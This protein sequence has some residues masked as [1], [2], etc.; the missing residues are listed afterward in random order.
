M[1]TLTDLLTLDRI[2]CHGKES[3]RK[4]VLQ[5][6]ATLLG[7]TAENSLFD[8][9]LARERLGSTAIGQGVALPHTRCANITEETG[10]LLILEQGI[11]Y[12]APDQ[13]R[14]DIFFA[15][16]VPDDD[17]A[18]HLET[19]AGLAKAFG[20]EGFADALR[21]CADPASLLALLQTPPIQ[22]KSAGAAG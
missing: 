16:S 7:A 3:S 21:Q 22:T 17:P 20:T 1:N 10:A 4:R 18:L 15:L 9:M 8:G 14:C 2:A 5:R 13:R 6:L 19:L 12:D 11:E